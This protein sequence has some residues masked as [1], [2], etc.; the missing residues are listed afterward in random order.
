[1][2][3]AAKKS[4][5]NEKLKKQRELRCWTLQEVADKLYDLCFQ[6]DEDCSL[7]SA[8]QVGRWERGVRPHAKYQ[9]KLCALYDKGPEELGFL[10]LNEHEA[11]RSVPPSHDEMQL[12]QVLTPSGSLATIQVHPY[13]LSNTRSCSSRSDIIEERQSVLSGYARAGSD[14]EMNRRQAIKAI[15]AGST[16]LVTQEFFDPET[17]D[18]LSKSLTKKPSG[19]GNCERSQQQLPCRSC[20]WSDKHYLCDS[21]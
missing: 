12:I 18:R 14:D 16:F 7:I 13:S 9:A 4:K 17:W 5:P 6:D 21:R 10:V 19:V 20:A 3:T 1:M 15:T 2:D 11:T 8:D